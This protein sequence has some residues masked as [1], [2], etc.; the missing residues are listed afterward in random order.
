MQLTLSPKG[1]AQLAN[2]LAPYTTITRTELEQLLRTFAEGAEIAYVKKQQQGKLLEEALVALQEEG[3]TALQELLR[4]KLVHTFPGT[5]LVGVDPAL[6]W[7]AYRRRV[8]DEIAKWI[9]EMQDETAALRAEKG[10]IERLAAV[11]YERIEGLGKA[12]PKDLKAEDLDT[13]TLFFLPDLV[14]PLRKKVEERTSETLKDVEAALTEKEKLLQTIAQY[15]GAQWDEKGDYAAIATQLVERAWQKVLEEE[16]KE[17][18]APH[19]GKQLLDIAVSPKLD[20]LRKKD[21][22]SFQVNRQ[23]VMRVGLEELTGGGWNIAPLVEEWNYIFEPHGRTPKHVLNPYAIR[24]ACLKDYLDYCAA[25]VN[26][27]K[28]KEQQKIEFA[29]RALQGDSTLVIADYMAAL[30]KKTRARLREVFGQDLDDG[31]PLQEL[32]LGKEDFLEEIVFEELQ[33]LLGAGLLRKKKDEQRETAMKLV[34]EKYDPAVYSEHMKKIERERRKTL[35]EIS[36]CRDPQQ[37]YD[38]VQVTGSCIKGNEVDRFR[39]AMADPATVFLVARQN[40]AL[41]AYAR[42][43]LMRNRDG[44]PVLVIDTLEMPEKNFDRYRGLLNALALAAVQLGLDMGAIAV[45]GNDG[46]VAHGPGLAF[47]N[48]KRK[49]ELEKL[50]LP[51]INGTYVYTFHNQNK[52]GRYTW[53]GQASLLMQNWK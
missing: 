36:V 29:R 13:E 30:Y 48:T 53:A 47:G 34:L 39:T 33:T 10:T 12:F 25:F 16:T 1:K 3:G 50:G 24:D 20:F 43:F 42:L 23:N 38:A 18:I 8:E 28:P 46:R 4:Q 21:G 7:E 37:L 17:I 52:E 6:S 31:K 22:K 40:G 32:I 44:E 41:N 19:L 45:V 15:V 49:V 27:K 5:P 35:Y 14:G 9:D 26:K 2:H 11:A 51:D